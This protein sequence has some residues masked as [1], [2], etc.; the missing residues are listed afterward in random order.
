M[1]RS[2]RGERLDPHG[3]STARAVII[4]N[5]EP[6]MIRIRA[7]R[8]ALAITLLLAAVAGPRIAR[9]QSAPALRATRALTLEAAGRA[10]MSAAAEA[11]KN[12]WNVSVSVVDAAGELIA[13]ARM[14]G[15]SPASIDISRAKGRT[16][17]R[18]R[19]PTKALEEA[20]AS[21]RTGILSFDGVIAVEG[22]VPIMIDGEF[23]GAVGVSGASSAQDAQCAQ[24]G[25]DAVVPRSSKP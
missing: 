23:V 5:P 9:A 4:R 12:G 22:G 2:S 1:P 16:A 19:R 11:K 6:L 10:M 18:L 25:V 20:V 3:A 13:F 14:D 15:A 17:A 24:A 7:L 8:S 21:G